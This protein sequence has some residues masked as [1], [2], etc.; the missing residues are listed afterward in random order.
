[1]VDRGSDRDVWLLIANKGNAQV[2]EKRAMTDEH[3]EALAVGRR[4]GNTVRSYLEVLEANKPKRGRKRTADTVR[5]NIQTIDDTIDSL[6]PLQR[7]LKVQ[8]RMDLEAELSKMT[9][10]TDFSE[11]ESAFV[12]VAAD[13]SERRNVSYQAWRT[14]GV[15]SE[16]LGRAGIKRGS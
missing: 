8:E 7:V 12:A 15:P 16:V 11:L 5:K 3:R 2:A 10:A 14:V 1:M 6:D 9:A 13:F 4:Q